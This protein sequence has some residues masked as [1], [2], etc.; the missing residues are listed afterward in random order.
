MEDLLRFLEQYEAWIYA[1]LGVVG[2]IYFRKLISEWQEWRSSVFG[3]ER[4]SAQRRLSATLAVVVI[5]SLLATAEFI[6]VSFVAPVYPVANML[7]TP[8]VSVLTTPAGT[9]AVAGETE[10]EE[11]SPLSTQA[12]VEAGGC[13]PGVLE[14]SFPQAGDSV[15]GV[16]KLKGTANLSNLGF[17]KYEFSEVSSDSWITIAAMN[18]QR[19]DEE[20]DGSWNTQSLV[21][22]DYRLRLVMTDNENQTLPACEITVRVTPPS[23]E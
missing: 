15:S 19:I 5:L 22:G 4:E 12:V 21:P 18:V 16:V 1:L 7:Q 13:A 14:W 6:L 17:F 23:E 10:P 3:L 20:L 9:F 2:F 8:T 11:I